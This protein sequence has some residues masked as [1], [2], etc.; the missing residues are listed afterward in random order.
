MNSVRSP[1]AI[2]CHTRPASKLRDWGSISQR[3]PAQSA[4]VS[5]LT[6]PCTWWSGSTRRMKSF[7]VHSQASMSDV[8]WARMFAW[9][10][11][12]PFGFPVVPLV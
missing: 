2:R 5:T 3:A 9:V 7:A 8:T 1:S 10:V 12:T 4:Q 6:M 11:T